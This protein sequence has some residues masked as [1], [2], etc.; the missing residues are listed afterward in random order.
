MTEKEGQR[1]D[2]L[3]EKFDNAMLTTQTREGELRARPMAIAKHREGATLYF[4]T[5]MHSVKIGELEAHPE[6]AV[7]M[8]NANQYLTL[9]GRA[10]EVR[11]RSLIESFF[12][13]M[14]K[15]WFPRGKDDPDL[16]LI[17]VEPADGEYWDMSKTSDKVKFIFQ[18]GKAY[19]AGEEID[20]DKMT[21]HGKIDFD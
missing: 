21:G 6:V 19:I 10:A 11:D 5:N 14:W 13:P 20:E 15:L 2:E 18:A 16:V 8:Q 17:K 1:F 9:S 3:V 7:T 12:S 4:A